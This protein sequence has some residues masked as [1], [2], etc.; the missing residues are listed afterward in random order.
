MPRDAH[1]GAIGLHVAGEAGLAD[2]LHERGLNGEL[3]LAVADLLRRH[4]IGHAVVELPAALLPLGPGQELVDGH[5][6]LCGRTHRQSSSMRQHIR[7]V[8]PVGG[9]NKSVP[10]CIALMRH[11]EH[12]PW[13]LA[14]RPNPPSPASGAAARRAARADAYARYLYEVGIKPLEEKALGVQ[15]LR[16]DRADRE[17]VHHHLLLGERGG[18]VAL[19]R[20]RPAPHPSPRRATRSS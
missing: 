6:P 13:I 3:H 19:R 14:S 4:E 11:Q 15:Q 5:F 1:R 16:E 20:R 8:R 17:R 10:R 12:P 7:E 18:D 9:M 2:A